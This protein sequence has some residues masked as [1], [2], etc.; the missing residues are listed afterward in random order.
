MNNGGKEAGGLC[1]EH[2]LELLLCH[3][4]RQRSVALDPS[5]NNLTPMGNIREIRGG[6]TAWKKEYR[7]AMVKKKG[8]GVGWGGWTMHSGVQ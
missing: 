5:F 6:V 3:A 7:A 2:H 4:R 1:F 8:S